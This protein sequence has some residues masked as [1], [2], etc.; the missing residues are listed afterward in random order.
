MG[1]ED[2]IVTFFGSS[3]CHGDVISGVSTMRKSTQMFF[4]HLG[5]SWVYGV[6]SAITE[7]RPSVY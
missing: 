5:W 6:L 7:V 3:D 4:N 2:Y 1:E